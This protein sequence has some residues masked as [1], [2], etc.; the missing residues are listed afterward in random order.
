MNRKVARTL[1]W[2]YPAWW[3]ERYAEE[4]SVFLEESDAGTLS[5]AGVI[6]SAIREHF[7]SEEDSKMNSLQ[8]ALGLVVLS[9]LAAALGG[10]NLVMTADDSLLVSATRSHPITTLAWHV[11]AVAAIL[12]GV[13]VFWISNR[14]CRS[15]IAFAW[16][17]QRLD[18]VAWLTTPFL[19]IGALVL[20]VAGCMAF[21]HGR[22]A[23]S[24][25]AILENG[26]SSPFWPSLRL[27]WICEII[28]V[29]L[30][31]ALSLASTVAVRR[32]IRLT[33]FD[34]ATKELRYR[35]SRFAVS[36]SLWITGCT[37]IMFISV[38][39]WGISLAQ[40]FPDL[41]HQRLGPLNG[42]AAAS[43]TISM[44]LFALASA[45]CIRA[46]RSIL[47]GGIAVSE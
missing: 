5:I 13:V 37:L 47:T 22:W 16:I 1:T 19:G 45:V 12:C 6:Y 30:I 25:W 42:S 9:F 35:R 44:S 24:P 41:V 3:R 26:T 32:A 18:I 39:I 11:L 40:T 14:L 29:V 27:R 28:S 36:A 23:P 17:N 20:W 31:A 10:I 15:I 34:T 7:V 43:W 4:F 8:R 21:T 46:S 33:D 38:L 2:F